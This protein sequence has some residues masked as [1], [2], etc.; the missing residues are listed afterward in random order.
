MACLTLQW[1]KKC[2]RRNTA[3]KDANFIYGGIPAS[4]PEF[5]P[6]LRSLDLHD[7]KLEGTLPQSL[8]T[9]ENLTQLQVAMN[10]LHCQ[11]VDVVARLMK[12]PKL[13]RV[14]LDANPKLCGCLP[15][16]PLPHLSVKFGGSAAQV[17]ANSNAEL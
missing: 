16:K 10:D 2:C 4:L 13:R 6:R 5:W 3:P 7:L 12:H 17:C 11:D 15:S 9:L 1:T 8:E 14:N